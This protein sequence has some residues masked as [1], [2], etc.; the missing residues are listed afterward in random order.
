MKHLNPSGTRLLGIERLAGFSD[1]R[2]HGRTL[3]ALD[4][5]PLQGRSVRL[6]SKC[7]GEEGAARLKDSS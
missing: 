6:R 7:P 1:R 4:A 5:A 3:S 2:G